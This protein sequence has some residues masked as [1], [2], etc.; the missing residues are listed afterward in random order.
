[1]TQRELVITP[2]RDSAPG[3]R[4]GSRRS[5]SASRG[6]VCSWNA[7]GP[8]RARRG[9]APGR[10]VARS[11]RRRARHV[12]HLRAERDERVPERRRPAARHLRAAGSDA[13]S[14]DARLARRPVFAKGEN[15]VWEFTTAAPVPAGAFRYAIMVD[16]VRTLDPV[17]TRTSE[18][19]T[20][21]WSLFFVPGIDL[22]E[23]KDVP[24]GA[25]AEVFYASS[26]LKTTRRMHVYTPPG[27]E[28]GI[29]NTRC[30][31]CCMAPATPTM[32]GRPWGGRASSSTT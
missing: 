24:H 3:R 15:G 9:A 30:S 16:G 8:G 6:G 22:E 11:A 4:A 13:R 7:A 12:P 1:M 23:V 28:S 31:T 17:N 27:Y 14:P 19:N 2:C 5:G 32:R 29:R 25:V 10:G 21:N 20:A 26:V 18:S